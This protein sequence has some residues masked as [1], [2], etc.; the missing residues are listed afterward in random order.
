MIANKVEQLYANYKFELTL[1]T[2]Q[3]ME[4]GNSTYTKA[5]SKGRDQKTAE[6]VARKRFLNRFEAFSFGLLSLL[7]R[8]TKRQS[9]IR[10]FIGNVRFRLHSWHYLRLYILI[11]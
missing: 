8:L 11:Y 3:A 2:E 10:P 5:L 1:H 4:A 7:P 6:R 9:A